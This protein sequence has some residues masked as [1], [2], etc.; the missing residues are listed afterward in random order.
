MFIGVDNGISGGLVGLS[1]YSQIVAMLPMPVLA[2]RKRTE[3]DVASVWRWM[4]DLDLGDKLTVVIEEPGGSKS[5][6]AGASMAGSF[7][8]LRALCVL[9][10]LRWHRITPQ[11]WQRV[12]LPGCKSGDT[13]PRALA[14]ARQLWPDQTFLASERSRKPHEGLI[15]AALIAEY[16]RRCRL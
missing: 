12:I 6:K 11:A 10:G 15:D 9:K 16:G 14:E 1:E 4:A 3:I 8:A 2:A 7:H 5:A 13:K